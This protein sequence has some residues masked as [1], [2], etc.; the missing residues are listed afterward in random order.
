MDGELPRGDVGL[1]GK[2]S[3]SRILVLRSELVVSELL[4]EF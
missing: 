3:E 1:G 2:D 4:D